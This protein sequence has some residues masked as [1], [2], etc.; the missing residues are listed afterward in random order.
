M[1]HQ[2]TVVGELLA[3]SQWAPGGSQ[4]SDVSDYTST[5]RTTLPEPKGCAQ[6]STKADIK[7]ITAY[8]VKERALDA[9]HTVLGQIR[10]AYRRRVEQKTTEQAIC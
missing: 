8:L 7:I 3:S 10:D 5:S 2:R 4:D 1:T 9:V 6:N